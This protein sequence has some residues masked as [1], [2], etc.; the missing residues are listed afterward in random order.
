MLELM[1]KRTEL[2]RVASQAA[3]TMSFAVNDA[4]YGAKK[5][6]P[7]LEV[8]RLRTEWLSRELD[9]AYLAISKLTSDVRL[10]SGDYPTGNELRMK[11][12][13]WRYWQL[14]DEL[15]KQRKTA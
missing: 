15:D 13:W 8:L 9:G 6:N 10:K 14:R 1:K 4:Y 12:S 5:D 11:R 2:Y 7:D 3:T